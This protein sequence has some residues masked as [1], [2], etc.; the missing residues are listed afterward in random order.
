M[1]SG[2]VSENSSYSYIITHRVSVIVCDCWAAPPTL[3]PG[4]L[5]KKTFSQPSCSGPYVVT[6]TALNACLYDAAS[7]SRY[8]YVLLSGSSVT[9][10][11][12][13]S[14]RLVLLCTKW[15][16]DWLT[17]WVGMFLADWMS[18]CRGPEIIV[19]STNRLFVSKSLYDLSLY[20]YSKMVCEFA[21]KLQLPPSVSFTSLPVRVYVSDIE[22]FRYLHGD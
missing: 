22:A 3:A 16:S 18:V 2:L 12:F 14:S 1:E 8:M 7:K 5:I 9:K 20:I 21:F 15:V 10:M 13:S 17:D 6:T 4:F 19:S 11:I